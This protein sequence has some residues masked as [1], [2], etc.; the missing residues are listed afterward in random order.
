MLCVPVA[1]IQVLLT[2]AHL[3]SRCTGTLWKLRRCQEPVQ[4]LAWLPGG[5]AGLCA[6]YAPT[7]PRLLL[8]LHLLCRKWKGTPVS[9][10]NNHLFLKKAWQQESQG[11]KLIDLIFHIP[12]EDESIPR[13]EPVLL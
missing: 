13:W 6:V 12:G 3:L 7:A 1:L 10:F 8:N 4:E 11:N 5:A 9:S 2:S